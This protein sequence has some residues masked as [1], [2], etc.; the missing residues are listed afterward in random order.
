MYA[1][2]VLLSI[3]AS[4]WA[5]TP[6]LDHE[7]SFFTTVDYWIDIENC[8]LSFIYSYVCFVF[9]FFFCGRAGS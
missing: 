7:S 2:S 1:L 6:K 9:F 8:F 5:F 4:T 3:K